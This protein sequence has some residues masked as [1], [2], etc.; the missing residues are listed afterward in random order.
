[1]VSFLLFTFNV[2][3]IRTKKGAYKRDLYSEI[4]NWSYLAKNIRIFSA[5]YDHQYNFRI[6][7][8]ARR[9]EHKAA[10]L[11]LVSYT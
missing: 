5:K 11:C 7:R 8:P 6:K 10:L 3:E 9:T 4:I 1:M 2:E